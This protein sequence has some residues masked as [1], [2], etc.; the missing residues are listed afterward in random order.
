[1]LYHGS[2]TQSAPR[3]GGARSFRKLI[4]ISVLCLAALGG[5]CAWLAVQ[6]RAE[7]ERGMALA[8]DRRRLQADL[9]ER[10][11]AL[12]EA[13]ET[14]GLME[15][16]SLL[17]PEGTPPDYT[18]LYPELYAAPWEGETVRG[19]KVVC[20]T[21]DDG[22]SANTDRILEVL[23]EY[24]VKATFFV[25]GKTGQ[26]DQRRMR[27][28][29]AAGHTLAIHSWSHDYGT[30]YASV[31]G[32]LEDFNRLYEWIYEVTGIYPQIFRFPGGS[33]NGYNRGI[34]QEIIAEMTRRGFVY[35]DWNASAQDATVKPLASDAIAANCLK[36]IGKE[37]VVVLAHD[38]AARSTTVDALP[39]IIEGY[40][41]EGYAF[42][43]L[44]PGI[45]PVIM[46]YPR[47]K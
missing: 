10:E 27:D 39:Q 11:A 6:Y 31:E 3:K 16:Y 4:W 22:P 19:G 44:D 2:R 46:G 33:V 15:A 14:I 28:I 23:D 32:F 30:I 1:M 5:V 13:R 38:S 43:P 36:G 47:E 41:A 8:D 40:R 12:A 37:E 17:T 9:E 35:F 26:E 29:V 18:R 7:L 25:V 21:F 45:E 20:L 24:G 42:L 34:Y